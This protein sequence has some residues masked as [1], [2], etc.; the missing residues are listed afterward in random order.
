VEFFVK[1]TAFVKEGKTNLVNSRAPYSKEWSKGR[2][3]ILHLSILRFVFK[4]RPISLRY[5]LRCQ[6]IIKRLVKYP[7]PLCPLGKFLASR[8][9]SLGVPELKGLLSEDVLGC[10]ALDGGT[11]ELLW[12]KLLQEH[13]K[14]ILE[15][16]AGVSTL[17]LAKY[18]ALRNRS[19]HCIVS[20][21]QNYDIKLSVE[22]RLAKLG[23]GPQVHVIHSPISEQGIYTLL[24]SH[25]KDGIPLAQFE[26]LLIDGP[27]GIEGCRRWTLPTLAKF[28]RRGARWFLH[29][30][31][32]DPELQILDEWSQIKGIV[33]EGIFPV[34]KGLATGTIDDPLVVS[35]L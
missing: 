35:P 9:D 30:A 33:V 24:D 26:W 4:H 18:L 34:G 12:R 2:L 6:S 27:A 10:W 23:L 14:T 8:G 22:E 5:W 15:C 28:C 13:P 20:L 29:D 25:Q 7:D 11:I 3:G 16:G 1:L 19:Y 31:L 32:R 21:E 17:V